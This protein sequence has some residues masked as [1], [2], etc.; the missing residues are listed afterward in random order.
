MK[1]SDI[2]SR[3]CDAAKGVIDFAGAV[4]HE[5]TLSNEESQQ[6]VWKYRADSIA[7]LPD[8]LE[9]KWEKSYVPISVEYEAYSASISKDHESSIA[10][11]SYSFTQNLDD[12][13]GYMTGAYHSN[14][15]RI[16]MET[17]EMVSIR[18][19]ND[20][21]VDRTYEGEDIRWAP[22][23]S[24]SELSVAFW[25]LESEAAKAQKTQ[26]QSQSAELREVSFAGAKE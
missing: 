6:R 25:H 16:N 8:Q 21:D 4:F 14:I 22:R 5:I 19:T 11:L 20:E 12:C 23:E 18:Y 24:W 1:I 17:G 2:G 9:S 10:T 13:G 15:W 7:N 3:A 26:A